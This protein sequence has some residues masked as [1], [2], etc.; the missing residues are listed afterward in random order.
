VNVE[1]TSIEVSGLDVFYGRFQ[2]LSDV[3]CTFGPGITGVLGPNGAGKSTL[4]Q[5]LTNNLR[6][7]RGTASRDG[8]TLDS[9][10]TWRD[11]MSTLGYLPQD[12]GWYDSFTVTE[13]CVY[14]AGLR[15]MPRKQ[16]GPAADIAIQSVGLAK[17]ADVKLKSLS[18]GMRRRAF[19]AQAIVHDPQV[20]IL[21]EPTSGLDPAQR[22]R[23]RQLLSDMQRTIIL[24]THLVEDVAHIADAIIVLDQGNIVWQGPPEALAARSARRSDGTDAATP[25]E[26]GFM[27]LMTTGDE[28]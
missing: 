25:W 18:G 13:L 12:P 28:S 9:A 4:F 5:V 20:L 17:R 7:A 19:L 26:R 6:P 21:D 16:R 15:A 10:R 27:S 2:A 8:V 1:T 22:L 23:L 11:H 24:S 3:S 14:M